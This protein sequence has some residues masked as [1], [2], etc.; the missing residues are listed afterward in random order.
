MLKFCTR[1]GRFPR[2]RGELPEEAVEFIARQV[3][4]APS[5]L[6]FYEWTGRTIEYQPAVTWP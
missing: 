4:V 1:A 2:G 5:D 3:G 6:G